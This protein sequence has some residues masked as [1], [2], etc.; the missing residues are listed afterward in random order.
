MGLQIILFYI[1]IYLEG[2]KIRKSKVF[3]TLFQGPIDV[4]TAI[5][6]EQKHVVFKGAIYIE[7]YFHFISPFDIST[8]KNV[9]QD[10]IS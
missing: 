7:F 9:Q 4:F 2:K 8:T 1:I 6:G 3:S 5:C 10:K